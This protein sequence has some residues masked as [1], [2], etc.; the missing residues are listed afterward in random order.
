MHKVRG[1]KDIFTKETKKGTMYIQRGTLVQ[2]PD[3]DDAEVVFFFYSKD[4]VLK[5]GK[6]Y[7]CTSFVQKNYKT[8][9]NQTIYENFKELA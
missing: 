8:K 5:P 2:F 9:E 3:H 6:E 7:S 1:S 4:D